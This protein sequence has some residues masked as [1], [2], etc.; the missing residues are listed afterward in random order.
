MRTPASPWMG[1]TRKAAVFGVMPARRAEASPK[2]M[3]LKP[4]GKGPKPSR[5]CSS[6]EKL[7]MEVVRPWKL[8]ADDDL[9]LVRG[10]ALDL[11]APLAGDLEGGLDGLGAGVHGHRHI[12]A[13]EIWSSWAKRGTGRCGRR[14]R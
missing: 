1:S 7:T 13:G 9:G 8:F 4:E 10:D 12:E 14:A 2:G 11:V 3:R 6:V 5:Y